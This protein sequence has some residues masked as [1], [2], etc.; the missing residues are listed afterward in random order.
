MSET[1]VLD[2]GITGNDELII[3]PYEIDYKNLQ[4][5]LVEYDKM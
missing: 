4:A 1:D 5:Y 3:E 2:K